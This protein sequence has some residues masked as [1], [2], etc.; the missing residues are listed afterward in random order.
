MIELTYLAY[1]TLAVGITLFVGGRLRRKGRAFL[2]DAF[3][4]DESLGDSA[5]Q[6]S[7]VTFYLINL[8][9][10]AVLLRW[11]KHPQTPIQTVEYLSTKLGVV[12]LILGILHSLKVRRIASL[13]RR[14]LETRKEA[15]P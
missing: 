7:L 9:V 15:T 10:I 8:G 5:N 2:V 13:R 12:L 1:L 14:A 11:G 4:G 3:A 6:L